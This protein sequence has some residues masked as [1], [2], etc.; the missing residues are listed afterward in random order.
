MG[1]IT[2]QLDEMHAAVVGFLPPTLMDLSDINVARAGL[3]ELFAQMPAPDLPE[4]V[5]LSDH[6]VPGA[7]GDPDV[8]VRVYTPANAQPGGPALFWMH[9]GGLVLLTVDADDFACASRA[10]ALGVVVASVDYRLAPE[11]PYP[12]PMNDCFAGLSWFAASADELGFDASRIV[13]GGASAGG[14]LAA[15]LAM[16]ARDKGGPAL[17][18]QFLVFPMLD[19]RNETASS[20]AITDTRVWN[21]SANIAA[22]AAYLGGLDGA[23]PPIYAVPARAS[24]LSGLPPAF[25]NIGAHDMF[26]DEDI[27]FARALMAAG[28]ACELKVY[29]QAF[30]GSNAFVADH[31][32]S[33]RWNADEHA[34]LQRLLGIA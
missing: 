2:G 16:M 26:L 6:Q 19:D 25:I 5:T 15:G 24:D 9:G 17:A 32:D 14:C 20:Q 30:H 27:V 1:D 8:L 31:P 12:G 33:I 21:R 10:A 4:G 7:D 34:A 3:D 28:V 22:W 23:E 29:P 11:T 13:V 18:G